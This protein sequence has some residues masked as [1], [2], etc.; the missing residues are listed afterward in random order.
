[1][2]T[3]IPSRLYAKDFKRIVQNPKF[4]QAEY[5]TVMALLINQQ[6]LPIRYSNHP[7]AGDYK[8]FWD[9]HITN[10]CV[11]IYKIDDD[12]LLLARIGSHS[13]LFR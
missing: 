10:D 13:E 9:C 7:L 6:L 3:P 2:L 5:L 11:L 8:G 1:M 12:E 4:N